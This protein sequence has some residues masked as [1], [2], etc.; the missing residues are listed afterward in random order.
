MQ[1]DLLA[2]RFAEL[3]RMPGAEREA[4]ARALNYSQAFESHGIRVYSRV[5][6]VQR[7]VPEGTRSL[8][9]DERGERLDGRVETTQRRS[10]AVR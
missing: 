6:G 1:V 7:F 8:S 2:L 9:A 5:V 10:G 3:R 4:L